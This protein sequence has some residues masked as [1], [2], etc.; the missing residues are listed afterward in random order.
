[1]YIWC[2]LQ[3]YNIRLHDQLPYVQFAFQLLRSLLLTSDHINPTRG[4][5]LLFQKR[6]IGLPLDKSILYYLE[7]L[8]VRRH[9]E[10]IAYCLKKSC[11]LP[12]TIIMLCENTRDD[13]SS[14]HPLNH[15]FLAIFRA[16]FTLSLIRTHLQVLIGRRK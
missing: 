6:A 10:R 4:E 13:H 16:D 7:A 8:Q 9:V 12:P 2:Q 3:T 14:L 15:T 5:S 11:C 1:M